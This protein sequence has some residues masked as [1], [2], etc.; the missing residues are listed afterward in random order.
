M[1]GME[2]QPW[3]AGFVS[4]VLAQAAAAVKKPMPIAGSVSCDALAAQAKAV[5][6]FSQNG[7]AGSIFLVRKT[8][9]DWTHTGFVVEAREDRFFTIEGNTNDD[10]EREGYEVCTLSRGYASKDFVLL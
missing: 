10:G 7:R 6:R 2:G 9:S 5:N 8:P 4:F 1:N 3:C